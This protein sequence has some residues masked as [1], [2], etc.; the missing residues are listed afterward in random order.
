MCLKPLIAALTGGLAS[1]LAASSQAALVAH[2]PISSATDSRTFLDD[3]IDNASHGVANG[4]T[5]TG[6][7]S[8]TYIVNDAFRGGDVLSTIE[9]HRYTAGTQ[10]ISLTS[11]FTWTLW[12]NVATSNTS[13]TGSDSI[14]GTRSE[15]AVDGNAWHKIDLKQTGS[16]NGVIP[17][18]FGQ[19]EYTGGT[20]ADGNWHFLAY[21]GDTSNRRLYK[22][23]VLIGE[24]TN[25]SG[26][27]NTFNGNMEIGGSSRYSEDVTGLYDDIAIWNERLTVDEAF[28]L[29]EISSPGSLGGLL[30][31]AGQFDLLKQVHDAGT[32]SVTIGSQT[33]YYATGLTEN[34]GLNNVS[35]GYNLVL[36]AANDTGLTTIPEPGTLVLLAAGVA[37]IVGGGRR[38]VTLA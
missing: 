32:G 17:G 25:T 36:D 7:T 33:W 12:V 20:L 16:W 9:G 10:N 4:T 30:Y 28:S 2:F 29:Y 38:R 11:G 24:D 3:V 31:T 22:D 19:S 27:S 13:D 1:V 8:H 23:G 35:G 18:A 6:S 21:V 26:Q 34:A 37:M 5:T 14:I 15:S